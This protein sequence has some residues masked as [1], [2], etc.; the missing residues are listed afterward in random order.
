[1]SIDPRDLFVSLNPTGLSDTELEK[2]R[3]G[4]IDDRTHSDYLILLA[5]Y[6]AG[7]GDGEESE[8]QR[9][10]PI[11]AEGCKP[12]SSIRPSGMPCAGATTSRSLDKAEGCKPDLNTSP[13]PTIVPTTRSEIKTAEDELIFAQVGL[14]AAVRRAYPV[15]CRLRIQ[16]GKSTTEVVVKGHIS[17]WWSRPGYI[18]AT[19]PRTGKTRTFSHSAVAEVLS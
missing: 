13:A 17:A 6:N 18:Q 14:L 1:M 5:G 11:N 9:H 7:A 15:G 4:F 3:S 16:I 19:N 8:C 10:R 12:E 2:D